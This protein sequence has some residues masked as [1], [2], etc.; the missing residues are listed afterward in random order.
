MIG[1]LQ[2]VELLLSKAPAEYRASFRREGV[3]HEIE[4]LA[5]RQL[6]TRNKEKVKEESKDESISVSETPPPPSVPVPMPVGSLTPGG[7]RPQ[8]VDPEDAYTLRA[9]VIKFRYLSND[10]QDESDASFTRLRHLVTG[11][12]QRDASEYQLNETLEGLARV[13]SSH[14]TISSF[15]LLQSGLLDGL[16]EFATSKDYSGK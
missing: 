12:K 7:R 3:L 1:G 4:T 16:L 11:L 9:R 6:S 2:M 15:E 14:Q 10:L 13:F 8:L 5:S